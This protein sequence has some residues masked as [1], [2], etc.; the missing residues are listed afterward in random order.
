MRQA[1]VSLCRCIVLGC[2]AAGAVILAATQANPYLSIAERNAFGLTN[3]PPPPASPAPPAARPAPALKLTGIV[4]LPG[5]KVACLLETTPGKPVRYFNLR[6]GEEEDGIE[7]EAIHA[8]AGI[9]TLRVNGSQSVLTFGRP[10]DGKPTAAQLV[11][12]HFVDEHTRAHEQ[13]ER[14]EQSRRER[15]RAFAAAGWDVAT[16]RPIPGVVRA[17]PVLPETLPK[18]E[19]ISPLP[20]TGSPANP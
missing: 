16:G 8:A 14:L 2:L 19:A 3:S 13:R 5:R 1:V 18:G 6:A 15:E 12:K 10:G 17:V 11:E 9:V 7:V 4:S 20:E